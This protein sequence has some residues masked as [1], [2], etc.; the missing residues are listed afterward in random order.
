M[1]LVV[2]GC[3]IAAISIIYHANKV[4]FTVMAMKIVVGLGCVGVGGIILRKNKALAA[5]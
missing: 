1:F 2:L 5:L 4:D 3:G